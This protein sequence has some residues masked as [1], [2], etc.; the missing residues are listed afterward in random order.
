MIE[1]IGAWGKRWAVRR[2]RRA[3]TFAI[4]DT[5]LSLEIELEGQRYGR[6]RSS[7]DFREGVEAFGA[8]RKPSFRGR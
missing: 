2:P 5:S 4:E 3:A 1:F 6:L 7:E 8:K